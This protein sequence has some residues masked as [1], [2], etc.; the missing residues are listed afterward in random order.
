MMLPPFHGDAIARYRKRIAQITTTEM[1]TWPTDGQLPIRDRMKDITFEVILQAVIGV[2]D[3]QR[4][5]RLRQLLPKLLDFSM[6][7]MWS[8][9]LFPRVLNSP[10]GRRHPAMRVR[11]EVDR[12]LY[13]EVAAHRAD[14]ERHDHILALLIAARDPNGEPLSDDNLL[15]QVLT[16]LLAGHE[17]TTTGLAW[18]FERL[19]RNPDALRRLERRFRSASVCSA[20]G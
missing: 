19:T 17:T 11:P 20:S 5:R 13:E 2:S 1:A 8:V 14:P 15:D 9:W 4:L 12:L 10:I 3:P 7:D 16:L 6:L 18:A